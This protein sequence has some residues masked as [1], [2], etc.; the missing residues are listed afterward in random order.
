MLNVLR[1]HR[2]LAPRAGVWETLDVPDGLVLGTA[3]KPAIRPAQRNCPQLPSQPRPP[4]LRCLTRGPGLVKFDQF[5][6][7]ETSDLDGRTS[8]SPQSNHP[9]FSYPRSSKTLLSKGTYQ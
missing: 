1:K 5:K 7:G 8:K 9:I 4:S 2:R 3:R 6:I